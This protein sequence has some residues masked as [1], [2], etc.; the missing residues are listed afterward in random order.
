MAKNLDAGK[1]I[2]VKWIRDAAKSA[3]KKQDECYTCG[4]TFDLELH[5]LHSLTLMF[6]K[7]VVEKGFENAN[8]LDIREDF[9]SDHHSEIYEQVYTLCNKHHMLL[10]NLF[11]QI[12]PE[13]SAPKQVKWLELQRNKPNVKP[14]V[15]KSSFAK[16]I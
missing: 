9:I 16:F 7:W 5:H 10:H 1:R 2:P 3:Y 6:D 12:P 8:I 14:G 15:V 11:G 4:T 13:N